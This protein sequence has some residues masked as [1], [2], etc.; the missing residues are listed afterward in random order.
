[1]NTFWRKFYRHLRWGRFWPYS[2]QSFSLYLSM[3]INNITI[4]AFV[5]GQYVAYTDMQSIYFCLVDI[6]TYRPHTKSYNCIIF[7]TK[8]TIHFKFIW[9]TLPV[10]V[11]GSQFLLYF[12][13][14]NSFVVF[15]CQFHSQHTGTIKGTGTRHFYCLLMDRDEIS[16]L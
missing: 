15:C 13:F 16:S 11:T 7:N 2:A 10:H 1:V 3:W 8:L 14:N 4:V 9:L 6:T 5:R 12:T